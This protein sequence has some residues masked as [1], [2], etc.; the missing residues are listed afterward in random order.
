MTKADY[1][2]FI[3]AI[4]NCEEREKR[5]CQNYIDLNPG[6]RNRIEQNRDMFLFATYMVRMELD[7]MMT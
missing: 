6:D 3:R 7:R 4:E 1:N 5:I 2:L